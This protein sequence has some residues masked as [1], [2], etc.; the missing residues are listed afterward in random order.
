MAALIFMFNLEQIYHL[1][2]AAW[3]FRTMPFRKGQSGNPGGRPKHQHFKD[4]LRAELAAKGDD[5]KA[6][7]RIAR[8]L[9]NKAGEGD[10]AAIREVADRLD[11]RTAQQIDGDRHS[12]FTIVISKEDAD[13]A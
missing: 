3:T 5:H 12:G 9:I 10:L 8:A 11:G 13:C 6:L 4:A 1:N 2:P 7:R